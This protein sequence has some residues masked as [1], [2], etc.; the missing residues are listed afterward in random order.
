[1]APDDERM[2]RRSCSLGDQHVEHPGRQSSLLVDLSEQQAAAHRRIRRGLDDDGVPERDGRRHRTAAQMQRKVPRTDHADDADRLAVDATLLARDVGGQHHA[3][4]RRRKRR[5]LERHR[6]RHVPLQ[7]GLDT[8]AAGFVN[9]PVDD[10]G[11]SRFHDRNGAS[12]HRRPRRG[13]RARPGRLR[14]GCG[15]RRRRDRPTAIVTKPT[16]STLDP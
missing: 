14:R 5:R 15:R 6:S 16:R 4:G 1:M 10:L 3:L 9:E 7:F 11:T 2:H 8:G 13:P 12:Q